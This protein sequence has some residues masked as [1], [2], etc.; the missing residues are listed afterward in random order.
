MLPARAP[1]AVAEFAAGAAIRQ[2]RLQPIDGTRLHRRMMRRA[3][4]LPRRRAVT[5][6][7]AEVGC[8]IS[9]QGDLFSPK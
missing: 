4:D 1:R 5:G 2:P 7:R 6:F 9:S 3:E 8:G